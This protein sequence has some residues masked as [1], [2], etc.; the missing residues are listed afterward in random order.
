MDLTILTPCAAASPNTTRGR[1]CTRSSAC[2]GHRATSNARAEL[3]ADK[4]MFRDAFR[5]AA[6]HY[7]GQ[8]V[9]R[10]DRYQGQPHLFTAGRR[11]AHPGAGRPV[12]G[13]TG[14]SR[15]ARHPG[16]D[17]DARPV[18]RA[19]APGD[20]SQSTPHCLAP[21]LT[22]IALRGRSRSSG[23]S[24]ETSSLDASVFSGWPRS[25]ARLPRKWLRNFWI[26]NRPHIELKRPGESEEVA[27]A[28]VYLASEQASFITGANLRVDGG[29]VA[30][31]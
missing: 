24:R 18:H 1:R 5:R 16:R 2:S 9:L 21:S 26:K 17:R 12:G 4:P 7:P 3:V 25:K 8:R 6:L 28:V 31:I 23:E 11:L 20:G 27:S 22:R 10:M 13:I 15:T 29:S 14:A 30:S 19:T